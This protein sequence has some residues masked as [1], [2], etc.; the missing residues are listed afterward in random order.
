MSRRS[1]EAEIVKGYFEINGEKAKIGDR[2]DPKKDRV[3]YKGKPIKPVTQKVYICLNKPKGYVTTLKDDRGR[4]D[5]TQLV[6]EVNTRVYPVGRLDI[7]S[8]GLVILTNDGEFANRLMHPSGGIQKV[9]LVTVKGKIENQVI[10]GLR[11]M[12][13]LEDQPIAPVSVELMFREQ[14]RSRIKMTLIEG[15]N[16]QIRRMCEAFGL[17]VT[18]LVRIK[19][20][21]V[22][23]SSLPTGKWRTLTKWE[24]QSLTPKSAGGRKNEKT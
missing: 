2:V 9:Y 10:D 23:L 16:R 5:I 13:M 17:E 4:K 15:K 19:I 1:A 3:S 18:D 12:R 8:E 22:L 7:D 21:G 6:E 11:E 20:G 14:E 24:I